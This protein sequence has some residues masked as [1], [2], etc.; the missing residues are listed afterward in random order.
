MTRDVEMFEKNL[1]KD[2][3]R[4]VDP[5]RPWHAV[6]LA[7]VRLAPNALLEESQLASLH[8]AGIRAI[9]FTRTVRLS[10]QEPAG[11]VRFLRFLR[12]ASSSGLRVVWNGTIDIPGIDSR[13]VH[14]PPPRSGTH[15]G[16]RNGHRYGQFYWR[17]GPGFVHIRD[18]RPDQG[19]ARILVDGEQDL[20]VFETLLTAQR[21]AGLP[22]DLRVSAMALVHEGIALKVGDW[23][24]IL[25]TRLPAWP[26]PFSGV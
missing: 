20:A 8:E 22:Q 3:P 7:P 12:D 16:W 13:I 5:I 24:T 21:L 10:D 18:R 23:V 19:A 4:R 9:Q 26:I 11:C 6:L 15:A 2:P 17:R 25:P 14:L 1:D